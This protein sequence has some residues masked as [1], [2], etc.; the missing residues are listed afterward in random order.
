[1]AI[2]RGEFEIAPELSIRVETYKVIR[3]ERMKSLAKYDVNVPFDPVLRKGKE[4]LTEISYI[5]QGDETNTNVPPE[6]RMN[7]YA[8]G[9]HL[10]PISGI[11]EHD[12]K[13]HED[14]N[15]KLLAFVD[16]DKIPR[17]AFMSEVEVVVPFKGNDNI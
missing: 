13:W 1:V 8:Y 7:A 10:V 9:P 12:A 17:Y 15:F 4:I 2:F 3:K 14:R 6:D 16:K 5:I 11:L